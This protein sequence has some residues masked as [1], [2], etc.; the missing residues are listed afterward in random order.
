MTTW[1]RVTHSQANSLVT[2]PGSVAHSE[3]ND[4]PKQCY[5]LTGQF[6]SDHTRQCDFLGGQWPQQGAWPLRGQWLQHA[7]WLTCR[8]APWGPWWSAAPWPLPACWPPP[9]QHC[10]GPSGT[11][12]CDETPAGTHAASFIPHS[13]FFD[14]DL[15]PQ[16]YCQGL[17]S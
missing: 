17:R 1:G 3:A 5:S 8:P 7:V 14:A 15:P 11:S 10:P 2:T 12:W 6:P 9:Q 4:H 16:K 13:D